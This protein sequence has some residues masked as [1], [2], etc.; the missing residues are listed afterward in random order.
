MPDKAVTAPPAAPYRWAGDTL[1]LSGQVGVDADWVPMNETFKNEARQ[2][3]HNI[4]TLVE[5]AGG[6]LDDV[7]FVRTYLSDFN[8]FAV[9]N[10]VWSEVFPHN[11]PAR[12]TIQAGLHPPFR[13]ESEAIA[14]VPQPSIGREH[15]L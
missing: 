14:N 15:N 11:P 8:D 4:K 7:A 2:V 3:F 5:E 6:T 12:A 10:E 9:F 1:Y 13:L